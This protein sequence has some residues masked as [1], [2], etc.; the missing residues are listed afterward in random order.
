MC[1][2]EDNFNHRDAALIAESVA[3]LQTQQIMHAVK[4]VAAR[5]PSPLKNI[6]L[7]GHGEFL[8]RLALESLQ[9]TSL[10]TSLSQKLKPSIS[11]CGPAHALAVLAREAVGG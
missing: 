3:D 2:D 9:L 8:A 10:V 6:I 11:R 4:D 1:A 5:L 7:T